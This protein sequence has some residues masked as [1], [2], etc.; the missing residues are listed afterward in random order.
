QART[1]NG[2][3]A[4]TSKPFRVTLAWT[5]APGNTTGN[6]YN[7]NLDLA[8]TIGGNTYKGNVF[9]GSASVTGGTNDVKNNVECVFI[10]AGVSGPFTVTV[11]AANINSDGVPNEA[12]SLDQDYALVIYNATPV[13]GPAIQGTGYSLVSENCG[14]PNSAVD[15]S[16][17]V[18]LNFSLQNLG[19]VN[20][21]NLIA[22]LLATN[23]VTSPSGAQSYGALNTNGNIVTLPF[24]FTA[25]GVCGGTVSPVF[26]LTDGAT[27]LGTVAFTIPLGAQATLQTENFDSVAAPAFPVGWSTT[28]GGGQSAWVTTTTQR[29]TLPNSAYSTDAASTGSNELISAVITLPSGASQLSFK[30]RYELESGSGVGYDGG[31]L[32]IKIGAGAFTDIIAAG[33]SFASGG[34]NTTLST[35]YSNPLGG[36]SAWS[37]TNA[38]FSSVVVNLPASAA[39]Q[40]VQFR[41]RCGSDSSVSQAGWWVDSVSLIGSVCCTGPAAPTIQTPPQS[42]NVI[43]G[44]PAN[45]SVTAVGS[46]SLAYQWYFNSNGIPAATLTNYSIATVA[47]TNAGN[48]FVVVSN[49]IGATT[50]SLATLTVILA[51]VIMQSPS[52]QTVQVGLPANFSVTAIGVPTLLYQ[53]RKNSNN[54]PGATATNYPLAS[55]TAGDAGYYDVIVTNNFGSVTSSPALLTTMN[56]V[57]FSGVLIGWDMNGLSSY[58]SSPMAA[59]TNATNVTVTAGLTRGSGFTLSGSAA[60]GGWGGNGLNAASASSSIA[61]NDVVT[62]ALKANAGYALSVTNISRFDYRRSGATAVNAGQLQYSLDGSPF[63]DITNISFASSASGGAALSPIDLSFV[64]ALQNVPPGTNITFRLVLYGGS[65]STANWYI[66]QRSSSASPYELEFSGNLT[67]II[68]SPLPP[69]ITLQPVNTNVFSGNPA[70]FGVSVTGSAPLNFQWLK[71]GVPVANGGAISGALTN[72]LNF[73]PAATNHAGNYSVIVTNFGGSVT[74][75]VA[76]LNVVVVPSLVLSNSG[77]GFVL[78]AGSGAVSNRYI[79]Q[80]ATN[81][82]SPIAWVPLVTNVI[83]TNG[84]IQFNETNKAAPFQFYRVLF[85]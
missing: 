77:G 36:R 59:S 63:T 18:T 7:N 76:A 21:T 51:P 33:G 62:F 30:H 8:V 5:D 79:V 32:E 57:A 14:T 49:N 65:S 58:G 29:D 78:A 13:A 9:T 47:A 72:A 66:Y 73:I 41:W 27:N 34:Y 61:S 60:G 75:S 38:T 80:R 50:S 11:T 45:F 53:W 3:V 24:T 10:S 15:P 12:P 28:A 84:L 20:T 64:A 19:T 81:L 71:G 43:G 85:P 37:G 16:E 39:G 4:D 46:G 55:V 6:A 83:G 48:Y 54:I 56:P 31:V 1:N 25:S 22:T 23:G 17:I 82:A 26:T 40:N 44:S 67:P 2:L 42:L 74:S 52:N 70:A 35:G 68:V 69:T